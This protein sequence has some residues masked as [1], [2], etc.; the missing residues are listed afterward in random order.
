MCYSSVDLL[1]G[2]VRRGMG[3][4]G[5][6]GNSFLSLTCRYCVAVTCPSEEKCWKNHGTDLVIPSTVP[7]RD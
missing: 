2:E 7:R 5:R 6:S 4:G 1:P 3:E